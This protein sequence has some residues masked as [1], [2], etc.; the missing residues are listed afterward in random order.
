MGFN[1]VRSEVMNEGFGEKEGI[2]HS[3]S[4]IFGEKGH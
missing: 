3:E 2:L 4:L 1:C